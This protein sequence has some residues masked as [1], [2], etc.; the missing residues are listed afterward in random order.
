MD[1]A[2]GQAGT[3][4][5]RNLRGDLAGAC[6]DLG[7]FLPYVIGA[8]TVAGLAPAGVLFGFA[9]FFIAS[10]LFY[11]VPMAVQPMKI[12]GAVVLTGELDAGAV[13]ATG[14]VIGAALLLLG[15]TGAIG[16]IARWIPQSVAAGLQLGVGVTMAL[17]G[18]ELMDGA[19]WFGIAALAVLLALM[20]MP[21]C[22]AAPVA[23]LIAV[24]AGYALGFTSWGGTPAFAFT[25]PQLMLPDWPDFR[26]AVEQ[27]VLPQLP[28]T[29]TNAVI[30]TAILSRGLFGD[31]ARRATE[32]NLALSNGAAN[33]LLAPFGAL[34][35]CHGAG[36]VQAQ[37]RFGARTGLAPVIMGA[38]LLVL[39]LG[40]ADS[41]AALFAMI[42]LP[43]VGALLIVA[44]ADLAISRR[45]FDARPDCWPAIV[46][47]AA[48]TA[49]VNP[50]LALVVGWAFE[51][52]RGPVL[53]AVQRLRQGARL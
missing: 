41:T 15:A 4:K 38:A 34:A 53:R 26:V 11:G 35:M 10:G 8:I 5:R 44:G 18:V 46:L 33:L 24:A 40:F 42:P 47:T 43:A 13:A 23:I 51:T 21:R 37:H 36:G 39:A 31:A 52:L 48:L 6:G 3:R 16:R 49:F 14:L 2:A 45:V 25:L 32:R 30:V 22:P 20:R 19:V 1:E 7:T 12:V 17:F 9:A 28:L 29:L 50:G 27:A